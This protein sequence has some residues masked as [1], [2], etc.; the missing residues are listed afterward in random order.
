ME[1]T[2]TWQSVFQ[3]IIFLIIGL[4]G[5]PI[6]QVFKNLLKIEDR[7][8]LV[9]TGIVAAILAVAEM[10]LSGALKWAEISPEMFPI[11][12]AQVMALASIYY[13]WMKNSGSRLGAGGLLK[14]LA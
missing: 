9:L 12:F 2:V 5:A 13:G 4:A 6:T 3:T 7:W 1:V 14:P 11:Y 10:F 8:A